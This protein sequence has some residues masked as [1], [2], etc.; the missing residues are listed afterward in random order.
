MWVKE[1]VS[2]TGENTLSQATPQTRGDMCDRQGSADGAAKVPR[3]KEFL[4]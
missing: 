3:Q 4:L 2:V 1:K